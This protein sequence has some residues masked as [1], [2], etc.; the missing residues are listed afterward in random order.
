MKTLLTSLLFFVLLIC[1]PNSR[2]FIGPNR[3]SAVDWHA[4]LA[5]VDVTPDEPVRMSGYGSRDHASEGIETPLIVRAFCLRESIES[6]GAN[7]DGK[8]LGPISVLVSIDNVGISGE[9]GR[10]LAEEIQRRHGIS[11]EHIVFCTTHTHSGPDLGSQLSNIFATPLTVPEQDAA[12]RYV[13]K[14]E[15][16]IVEAVDLAVKDLSPAELHYGSGTATFAANRRVLTD[17]KWTGFGVQ[18]DGP[19]DHSVPVL[20]IRS[21]SGSVRGVVFNYACHCTTVGGDYY[22]IN[23]DWAGYAATGLEEAFPGAVALCT[24]GCGADANPNPRG[25]VELAEMHG[26]ELATEV[27]RLVDGALQPIDETIR[28]NF[29]YAA[30]SFE[31]PTQEELQSRLADPNVQARRHAEQMLQVY[32]DKGRLPATYPVPIQSWSFG[33]QLDMVFIGGEVVVDY[34]TRLKKTLDRPNLWVTAYANDVLGYIASE[35]MRNEGG[36]E[37]D[38]SGVYYGLPGPWES[39]SETKLIRRIVELVK[40]SGRARPKTASDA[41]ETLRV[42]EGFRVELVA[43]E[44]L[45]QDPVNMAFGDDGRLWVVEMGDYPEGD[46]GGRV[47]VLMDVDHDGVYDQATVF[48]SGLSFP[49]GVQPWQDGVLVSAAPD[50]LFAR[51]TDGDSQADEVK[52]VYSGFRLANPQHRINGFTYALDHSFHLAAGDNLGELKSLVTGQSVDASGCDVVIR[53]DTGAISVTNGRTQF[54]RSR[55]DFGNWFGNS[56]SHPMFHFPVERRYLERNRWAKYTRGEQQLFWP[57]SAPP[58]FPKTASSERFNDLFA[59][60]RFTSACSSE[61]ARTPGFSTPTGQSAFICEPVHNLVHRATLVPDGA[62]YRATRSELESESE[63]LTSS[64]PWFRPVRSMIG[65]DGCLYVVD[66]YR[67]VIEH[68]EWIPEAWQQSLNV[69]AGEDRGRIYRIVPDVFSPD[70]PENLAEMPTSELMLRLESP[71]GPLRD[72]AQRILLCRDIENLAE[73][74]RQRVSES[75]NPFLTVHCLSMLSV[76]GNLTGEDLMLALDH[77]TEGVVIH[78]MRLGES[79]LDHAPLLRNKV[80][81]LADHASPAV[82]K[83]AALSLG[84]S[85]GQD[86]TDALFRI[87]CRADL[88]HW[89]SVAI[90]SSCAGRSKELIKA[91]F[92]WVPDHLD[93]LDEERSVLL[94]QVLTTAVGEGLDV[95]SLVSDMVGSDS[96]DLATRMQLAEIVIRAVQSAGEK[97]SK[98]SGAMAPLYGLAAETLSDSARSDVDRCRAIG[99]VSLQLDS[100]D[101]VVKR[102]LLNLL[103]PREPT[104]VQLRVI[105]VIAERSRPTEMQ[106]LFNAW[107]SF[108]NTLRQHL[109]GQLLSRRAGAEMLL[110]QLESGALR[111]D[112]LSLSARSQLLNTGSRSMRVRAARLVAKVGSRKRDLIVQEYLDA[113]HSIDRDVTSD[114][115]TQNATGKQL[116]EKHCAVCHTPDS[117][118]RTIGASLD[119]LTNRTDSALV[120]AILNPNRSVDP[121]FQSYVIQSD[122]GRAYAGMIESEVADSVTIAHA[123]GKRTTI[124]RDQIEIMKNT[125]ASLMPEGFETSMDAGAMHRLVRYLQNK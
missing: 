87:G 121:K 38:R 68:P 59:A 98:L 23:A 107:P 46:A 40:L 90:V 78:S 35:R 57:P 56:N 5:K 91:M 25:R 110:A 125:G 19:V 113:F 77:P 41:V 52:P 100:D 109:V 72:A 16:G 64:D 3:S 76:T 83:Q 47:K 60:N 74:L 9:S 93:A 99:L 37:F 66:M 24:I 84:D 6:E 2:T 20:R 29:D 11:R 15:S 33:D 26:D 63:F 101:G 114:E 51:D 34:A 27:K 118:G 1:G 112:E 13:K 12:R 30:L 7:S 122:Q 96:I 4:G 36:Y 111:V 102:N 54:M 49:T 42:T 53:P 86:A 108:S 69:R 62:S 71:I 8:S 94:E 55:D 103:T 124:R 65:H 14:L 81:G 58:V 31:L 89:M 22:Q 119:N 105:D 43:A 18:D 104:A 67:E 116:F 28:C 61:V 70:G 75:A 115:S 106:E 95:Q 117:T 92:R 50:I 88:D 44:P 123:D 79:F 73:S 32:R 80:I 85:P 10:R 82:A 97:S 39:G 48:L 17:G 120:E 21:E 45:V